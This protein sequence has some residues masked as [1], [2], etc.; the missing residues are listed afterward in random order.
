[1]SQE[2]QATG[3]ETAR[4]MNESVKVLQECAAVQI[5]KAHDYQN[6]NSQVKQS[7]YYERG[8]YSITDMINQKRLRLK[9][10]LEA[11]EHSE[12]SGGEITSPNYES[13]EDTLK[14]MINYA[15]FGVSWLRGKIPGQD[16]LAG[17]FNRRK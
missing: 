11:M 12:R 10:L 14:D 2:K 1:M 6:P 8:I 3:E 16:P 17:P 5:K 15:S 13:V 4:P 7:D 9:S